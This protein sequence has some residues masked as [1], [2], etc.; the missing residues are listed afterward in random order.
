ML[1]AVYVDD[2]ISTGTNELEVQMFRNNF[3]RRFQCS[4]G[5]LMN[6]C[7][8]MEVTQANRKICIN[9]KQ[10][11]RQK[12]EEFKLILDEKTKRTSPLDCNFQQLLIDAELSND[13][14]PGFPYREIVG[15]LS[16]AATGTR[17]DISAAVSI[18]SRFLE[19]PKKIHCDMVRR[20]LYYLRFKLILSFEFGKETDIQLK[21]YCDA[22]WANPEDY[23][24]I[25]GHLS[26][27]GKSLISWSSKKQTVIALSSSEAEYISVSSATQEILWMKQTTR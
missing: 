7:L 1:V 6:W 19:K 9:Q 3:K 21:S 4:E 15:S 5:G 10:Y 22:S 8:G 27:L 2:I 16:Y 26:L 11:V 24:S 23:A 17:P 25:S 13:Y 12:F 20:I 18:V 14:E